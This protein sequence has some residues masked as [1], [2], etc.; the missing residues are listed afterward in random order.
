MQHIHKMRVGPMSSNAYLVSN[1]TG[2]AFLVD[3]G[4]NAKEILQVIQDRQF[5]LTMILN[6]HGHFDHILANQEIMAATGAKLYIHKEDYPAL[7]DVNLNLA[8]HF[9]TKYIP[10]HDAIQVTD[11]QILNFGKES[12]QVLHTPGH[13]PGGVC[14][15][16][17]KYLFT[18]DTLFAG[19]IGRTDLIGGD[20]EL[21]M[22]SIR[23]L[24]SLPD[25]IQI[26]PGHQ[27]S[28]DVGTERNT[29]P[30]IRKARTYQPPN[31]HGDC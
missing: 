15:L 29:N 8:G 9:A 18:G 14:Y 17:E 3:A 19:S 24:M 20:F 6:T 21:L 22:H 11:G 26:L 13:T 2:Q 16:Y 23:S 28:S 30:W 10:V 25:S 4:G 7:F 27:G 5:T 1:E 12:I 31:V